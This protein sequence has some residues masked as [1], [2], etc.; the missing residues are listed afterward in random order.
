[1]CNKEISELFVLVD[2]KKPSGVLGKSLLQSSFSDT[3]ETIKGIQDLI[4]FLLKLLMK[5]FP[6]VES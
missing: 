3:L 4:P 5:M 1:M 6:I 2:N